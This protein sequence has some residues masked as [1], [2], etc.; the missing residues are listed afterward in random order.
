MDET[1]PQ[2]VQGPERSV[3]LFSLVGLWL[4]IVSSLTASPLQACHWHPTDAG[5][6][7]LRSATAGATT[8]IG[9]EVSSTDSESDPAPAGHHQGGDECCC[10][11]PCAGV[12]GLTSSGVRSTPLEAEPRLGPVLLPDASGPVVSDEP[13]LLPFAIP[14]P[15]SA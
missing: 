11:A 8:P 6:G 12:S 1:L 9:S 7:I 3:R 2:S 15:L 5:S 10:P 4:L 13:F 14:P